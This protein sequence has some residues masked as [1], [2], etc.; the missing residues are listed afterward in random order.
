M[1]AEK[2]RTLNITEYNLLANKD[3][4]GSYDRHTRENLYWLIEKLRA[5]TGQHSR[6]EHKLFHKFQNASFTA[7]EEK[8]KRVKLEVRRYQLSS[9]VKRTL[10]LTGAA[11]LTVAASS[12]ILYKFVL[13]A[14]AQQKVDVAYY[15]GL[16]KLGLVSRENFERI[17]Q[18]FAQASTDL[19]RARQGYQELSQTV[20]KMILNN[21]VAENFKYIIKRI[22]NDPRAE[23]AVEG[24]KVALKF[25]GKT[26]ASYLSDPQRWY[27]VGIVESGVMRVYY[28]NEQVLEV[29]AI[30]GRKGE[31]TPLGKY[32]I[33]NKVYKPT[34]YKR[35]VVDG[36]QRVRAIPFG[37]PEH[38]IGY[39]WMGLNKLDNKVPGSYGIHGVNASKVNE[40][41]KKSFD[42]RSGSA[43]CLNVQDWYLNFLA[44]VLP[45]GVH[46]EIVAKDK[47]VKVDNASVAASAAARSPA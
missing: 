11:F 45:R 13:D 36:K 15:A 47:W 9:N 31:E 26:L 41:Y 43:G 40:F 20:E 22:Y 12:L 39:W 35:E 4:K 6:L 14:S 2:L 17:K 10:K 7:L 3:P 19:E 34:W 21:K 29:E 8:E 25:N 16:N 1:M 37:D 28:D 38:D 32:E 18:D 33:V 30:F 46:V 23:Y 44:K 5:N 24:N 42:W 27:L